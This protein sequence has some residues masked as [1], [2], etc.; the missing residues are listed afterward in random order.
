MTH[1][2]LR[3]ASDTVGKQ[4]A[5]APD[6]PRKPDNPTDLTKPSWVYVAKRAVHSFLADGC[7]DLA[8]GLTYFAVLS[9][10]PALLAIISLLGVVGQGQASAEWMVTFL[11]DNAPADLVDLLAEP[12]TQLATRGGSGIA[13][14]I[15]ILGAL[16]AASG[17]VGAFARAMNKVYEVD[18]GRPMWK[19]RPQQMAVTLLLLTMV[20]AVLGMFLLAGPLGE[21]TLGIVAAETLGRLAWPVALVA[22]VI[23]LAILYYSTPNVQQPRFRWISVGAFI[24]LI[25]MAVAAFGFTFYVNNFGRLN[26]MYG[27]VGSVIVLLLGLWIMNNVM[28]F[29]AEIDTELERGRQLQAGIKA[30]KTLQLP[31]RDTRET[32]KAKEKADDLV[33]EARRLRRAGAKASEVGGQQTED[34]TPSARDWY[35]DADVRGSVGLQ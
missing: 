32:K 2:Q 19:L 26:A 30:E 21:A 5:P 10:F 3:S 18:E 23:M 6:D 17:Y 33:A 35:A 28:L 9:M 25:G 20:I 14:V 1:D 31:P 29:G 22:G 11:R 27:A 13:L 34:S 15:G 4:S 12:I 24:A 7:T 8:A 16:W